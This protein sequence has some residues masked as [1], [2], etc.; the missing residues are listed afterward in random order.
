[1]KQIVPFFILFFCVL[2]LG[3]AVQAQTTDVTW[4]EN[5]PNVHVN[6]YPSQTTLEGGETIQLVIEQIIRP[7]W[8]TY[9]QNPGD[10]GDA[11]RIRW[12]LPEGFEAGNFQW[13]IPIKLP[14][15][16]LTNY[17]FEEHVLV[18]QDL[19]LPEEL[20]EGVI[21]IPVSYDILVCKEICIPESIDT[22]LILNDGSEVREELFKAAGSGLPIT[23]DAW[24]S[25]VSQ[26]D[27]NTLLFIETHLP[28]DELS[29]FEIEFFPY[30]YGLVQNADIPE[31][32]VE[33][34]VISLSQ[35]KGDFDLEQVKNASGV[36]VLE[37]GEGMRS[38]YI[39]HPKKDQSSQSSGFLSIPAED[40]T[41]TSEIASAP[42]IEEIV[43]RHFG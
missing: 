2:V 32:K 35:A 20:P 25:A 16:P 39:I 18:L 6:V 10:S 4:V 8:H 42:K 43:H 27:E 11:M 31:V 21:E 33:G 15:G 5:G 34:S 38:G 26:D 12:N 24:S 28:Q 13:P 23:H 41:G 17:G 40:T 37:D 7:H 29:K 3:T 19:T 14:V 30:E 1:M 36:I 9:W 22:T